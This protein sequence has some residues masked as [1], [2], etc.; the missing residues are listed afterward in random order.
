MSRYSRQIIHEHIRE[1]GQEKLR[2][3][4]VTLIGCG[5]L[6]TVIA[7]TLA[8][9][10]V[11]FLRI[12][13]RDFVELNNLQRQVLFDESDV[14]NGTPKAVAAANKLAVINSEISIEPVVAD[15]NAG[16]IEQLCEGAHL[17]LDGTDNF[18]TRYLINDVAVKHKI[19]WVYGA[20]VSAEGMVMPI[21]PGVT[22][23]LRCIF[24]EPPP[25][26]TSPTCD[27]AGVLSPI[28]NIVASLQSMEAMKILMGRTE[29]LHRKLVQINVWTGEFTAF[30][31][32]GALDAG[33]CVCCKQHRYDYLSGEQTGRT[34]SLC[35]RGAV[36]VRP[37]SDIRIV[38]EDV[39]ARVAPAAK[40]PPRVNRY[41]LRFEVDKYDITLFRDGR[42]II[43]GAVEAEEGRTVY[44]RYIGN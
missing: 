16:N 20:C 31:M 15:A 17:I 40:N 18:E 3:A 33:D 10:G 9:A 2:T 19:P 41:L 36:Q 35:G 22:P 24:D 38:L 4:R 39:A 25:P 14:T 23:C 21:L 12:V 13:D 30:D 5:A 44:A 7:N 6:G 42:A 27:T 29:A 32:Q 34:V 26:G 11:G 8:R 43:K 1:A 37:S 28:V